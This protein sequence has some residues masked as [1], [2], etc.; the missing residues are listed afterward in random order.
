MSETT[1]TLSN[2]STSSQ[3]NISVLLSNEDLITIPHEIGQDNSENKVT[4]WT[5]NYMNLNNSAE[6]GISFDTTPGT[7]CNE[8][9]MPSYILMPPPPL[10]P[11]LKKHGNIMSQVYQV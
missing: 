10:P 8:Q 9:K 3:K 11:T 2:S 1:D 5:S 7:S 4:I 6:E